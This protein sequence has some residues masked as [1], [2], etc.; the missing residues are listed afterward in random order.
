MPET[1]H[2][3][4]RVSLMIHRASWPTL[5]RRRCSSSFDD[6]HTRRV[7]E[8]LEDQHMQALEFALWLARERIRACVIEGRE[9]NL[10]R[11]KYSINISNIPVCVTHWTPDKIDR[12]FKPQLSRVVSR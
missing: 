1:Y 8:S 4:A 3:L 7:T 6:C 11:G 10:P 2:I 12:H 9:S 5:P